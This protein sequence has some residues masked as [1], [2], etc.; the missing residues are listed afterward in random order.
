VLHRKKH[1]QHFDPLLTFFLPLPTTHTP[2]PPP[3]NGSLAIDA[4]KQHTAE[5]EDL[6]KA[7]LA[8]F[9]AITKAAGRAQKDEDMPGLL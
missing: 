2:P 3:Q 9:A 6:K 5:R 4:I 8:R 7:A 1:A